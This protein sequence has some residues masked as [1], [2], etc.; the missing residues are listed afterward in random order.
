MLAKKVARLEPTN[1]FKLSLSISKKEQKNK[2]LNSHL[3][4]DC[5]KALAFEAL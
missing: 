1:L 2:R 3:L 5:M 4:V